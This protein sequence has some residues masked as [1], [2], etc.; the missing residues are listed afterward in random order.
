MKNLE[1]K[2]QT[3]D[4]FTAANRFLNG[5]NVFVR[6]VMYV[7]AGYSCKKAIL[8]GRCWPK[9]VIFMASC[10]CKGTIRFII[11]EAFR[12]LIR[13]PRVKFSK[14]CVVVFAIGW[15]RWIIIQPSTK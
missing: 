1:E 15:Q 2:F 5:N 8:G 11:Q 4:I 7:L 12:F 3:Q 6:K 13:K 9:P 14:V 10:L